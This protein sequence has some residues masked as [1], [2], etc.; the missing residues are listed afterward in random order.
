MNLWFF[1]AI[2]SINLICYYKSL[3][4]GFVFDDS[5]AITKNKDVYEGFNSETIKVSFNKIL[6]FNINPKPSFVLEY[7]SARFLGE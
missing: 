7:F 1:A 3:S 6:L 2:V 4:G 5:V